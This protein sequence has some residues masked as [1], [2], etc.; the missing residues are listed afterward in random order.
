MRKTI[1]LSLSVLFLFS[2]PTIM[3]QDKK[4]GLQLEAGYGIISNKDNASAYQIFLSPFYRINDNF[5]IGIG[6][7]LMQHKSTFPERS[8]PV[9]VHSKYRLNTNSSLKPFFNLKI[10]YGFGSTEVGIAGLDINDLQYSGE[11]KYSADFFISP[12]I[13]VSYE[14][15]KQRSLFL[16][17]S[18]DLLKVKTENII[19]PENAV[20]D[21][22]S[23]AEKNNSII[24]LRL[25]YEF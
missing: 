17:I 1:L 25:G 15:A 4:I 11:I 20:V 23:Y 14:I 16:A 6:A 22:N 7:G 19:R 18:Y 24:G 12:S 13:G 5:S 9:Y 2:F 8:Y 3:A 10:G 21:L